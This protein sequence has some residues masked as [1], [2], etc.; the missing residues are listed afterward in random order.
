MDD[1]LLALSIGMAL[2]GVVSSV[3]I[4]SYLS[5]RGVKINYVLW[6][7][8][9]PKYVSEYR[10]MTIEE[11]GRPGGWYYSFVVSMV[12]AA[13]LALTGFILKSA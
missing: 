11:G 8:Y 1:A 2:W 4:T 10:E 6:R 9:L 7:L 12:S 13:A 3:A 5:E